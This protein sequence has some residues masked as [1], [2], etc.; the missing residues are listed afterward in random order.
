MEIKVLS[1]D[2]V[3]LP[4][5]AIIVNLFEGVTQPSGATGAVD[6]ALGGAISRLI[7]EGEIKGK[8]SEVT[9][10]HTLGKIPPQ[11][12][13]VVGLGKAQELTLDRVRGAT[14][15]V[16]RALRRVGATQ[17]ATIVHGVGQGG[18][19]PEQAA[20]AVVEGAL[21]GLYT[22]RRHLTKEAE[23]KDIEE[24]TLVERDSDKL[25][26]LERGLAR[27]RVLAE[28]AIFA[29]DMVNE[30]ANYMTP[31][32]MA[33]SAQEMAR[34]E[35][36]ECTV[37]DREDM[38]RLGM[39][40]LL[41]VAQGSH[42]PPRF[43]I[44]RYRGEGAEGKPLGFIGKGITFDSGGISLKPSEGMAEMKSDMAGGA[45]VVGA[46]R[47]IARLKPK[48]IVTG[49]VPCTENLPGGAAQKPGDVLKALN[50]KTVEVVNTDAEGR[51][52]LSDALSYAVR[53]G[54]GPLVDLATLTGACMVALGKIRSGAFTN[55][56]EFLA[57]VIKAA[58]E[59]GEKLWQLP[60]DEEYKEDNKS[61][62][63]DIKNAG[64]RWGGAITAAQFLAEFVGDTP[65]VHL[66]IAGTAM[67]DKARGYL[68]NGATGV[69]AR[70]L[71]HLALSY[72]KGRP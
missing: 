28:A 63:A 69:G 3:T 42:Q 37:L 8:L 20:Q 25:S 72:E 24:L 38:Q 61:Q 64:S 23:H 35:G 27:G 36:L 21:L 5:K 17:V 65:W 47:A 40:A 29:R 55:N 13:A 52:I 22:F 45:A 14:A 59:A 11:R 57:R 46:M 44:L 71:V 33:E 26:A 66:D 18:I 54:I 6:Q 1:A 60:M 12:V 62:V 4:V 41:A 2:I 51:L 16:C 53:E 19:S 58:E 70:S 48:V 67:T 32:I 68:V 56:Q 43:I 31:T 34:A 49:L 50:G 30:P 9:L 39:G 7:T 15:E 10:L